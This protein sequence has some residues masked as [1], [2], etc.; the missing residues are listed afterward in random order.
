MLVEKTEQMVGLSTD[1]KRQAKTIKR[2][3]WWRNKKMMVV[4]VLVVLVLIYVI[5]V[6]C[7]GGFKMSK[8]F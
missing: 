5:L 6:I 4:V 8:C 1:M 3:M 2:T 7:C